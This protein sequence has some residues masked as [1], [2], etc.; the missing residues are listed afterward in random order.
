MTRPANDH[1]PPPRPPEVIDLRNLSWRLT[2]VEEREPETREGYLDRVRQNAE[3]LRQFAELKVG[4]RYVV[5]DAGLRAALVH[6]AETTLF[7]VA[8]IGWM[9]DRGG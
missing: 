2:H 4:R 3:R 7:E 5:G 6:D 9:L 8:F 1:L